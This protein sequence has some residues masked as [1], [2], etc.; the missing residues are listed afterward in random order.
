VA[1]VAHSAVDEPDL[2]M[3]LAQTKMGLGRMVHNANSVMDF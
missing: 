1:G 2:Y 3:S